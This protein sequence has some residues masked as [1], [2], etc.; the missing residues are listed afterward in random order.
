M[1]AQM[2]TSYLVKQGEL[3]YTKSDVP[4][5]EADQVLVQVAAVGVCGSDI[6]YYQHGKIGPFVVEQP[7]ILGHELSG[8]ITAVGSQ[9]DQA[10][11]GQ[12]VAVEPQR[13]CG[14]CAMCDSG[15]YNLCPQM[16]FFATPPIDGAFCEYVAIQSKFAFEIPDSISFNAAALIEPLSVAIWALKR[17]EI[18]PGSKVLVAGAGPI[19]VIVAQTAAAMGAAEVTVTDISEDR[20]AFVSK[21]GATRVINVVNEALEDVSVDIFIDASGSG[22]AVYAGIKAVGPAGYAILVGMGNDDVTLP[23]SHI[24]NNEIWVSG[25]FRYIDT[26]PLAIEMLAAGRID[27]DVLVTSTFGLGQVEEALNAGKQPGQL[28][29]IVDP[30]II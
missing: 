18:K 2:R 13:P 30:R 7:L 6:H 8:T 16:Q 17:A 27:L 9:V 26:W 14:A 12:R 4:V 11:I 25:V 15:R 28:K 23:I 29:T 24:Q 22:P 3:Q 1:T 21:H 10:R 20:L 5:L 19:G